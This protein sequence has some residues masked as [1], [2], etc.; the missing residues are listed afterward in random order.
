MMPSPDN[1][2][3]SVSFTA[4][5]WKSTAL[6]PCI[7]PVYYNTKPQH[8]IH[9][10]VSVYNF[11]LNIS[12]WQWHIGICFFVF[13]SVH[14]VRMHG[15]HAVECIPVHEK[16]VATDLTC[17]K[18]CAICLRKAKVLGNNG[19]RSALLSVPFKT[20][21][22]M[23]CITLTRLSQP[24]ITSRAAYLLLTCA[25]RVRKARPN[26]SPPP[27][28]FLVWVSPNVLVFSPFLQCKSLRNT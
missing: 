15:M 23:K 16:R 22:L 28:H 19:C 6:L 26:L 13:G 5:T 25:S 14:E 21:T 8:K 4:A 17:L 24:K 2:F 18:K 7:I 1:T 12:Y 9:N 11:T 20:L 27:P 3:P 10:S